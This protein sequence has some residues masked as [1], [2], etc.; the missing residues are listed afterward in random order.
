MKMRILI[1]S[2]RHERAPQ[3]EAILAQARHQVVA[4]IGPDDDL[5]GYAQRAQPD[6]TIIETAMPTRDIQFQW[7]RLCQEQPMPVV[8]FAEHSDKQ[9]IRKAV[10]AGVSAYVVDGFRPDRVVAVLEVAV[11]RFIEFRTLRSQCDQ[12]EA[13]LAERKSIERAKGILM[14]RRNLPENVAYQALRK[15][16]MD[17]GKRLPDVAESIITAEELLLQG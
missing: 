12:V 13:R 5:V 17:S 11:A 14:R 4:V 8:V 6:A 16:A 9:D 15:M 2:D 10:Q 1:A 7:Q 3:L